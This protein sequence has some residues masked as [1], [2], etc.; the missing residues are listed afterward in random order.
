MPTNH[1]YAYQVRGYTAEYFIKQAKGIGVSTF[2]VVKKV[3]EGREFCEQS[4]NSC[5][6]IIRLKEKYSQERLEKAC[7]ITLLSF[8]I[9]YQTVNNILSNNRDKLDN[10]TET[11]P[12]IVTQKTHANIRGKQAYI[13]LFDEHFTKTTISTNILKH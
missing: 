2:E 7:K 13:T 11:Q 1:Q 10:E 4:Y 3:L 9:N 8:K 5:L 6:G 12:F